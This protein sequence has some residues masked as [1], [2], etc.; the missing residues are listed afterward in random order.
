MQTQ[1][2]NPVGELMQD[3]KLVFYPVGNYRYAYNYDGNKGVSEADPII[4]INDKGKKVIV[5]WDIDFGGTRF[6]FKKKPIKNLITSMPLTNNDIEEWQRLK[7]PVKSDEVYRKIKSG[8][9]V[10]FDFVRERDYDVAA[11]FVLQSWFSDLLE[12]VFYLEI[13][14]RYG[15]GKTVLLEIFEILC[16]NGLLMNEISFAAI[17]RCIENY[18]LTCLI[19]EIDSLQKK[20]RYEIFKILRAGYRK[21]SQYIRLK[22]KTFEVECFKVF[23]AKAFNYRS[24]IPDDL[25]SRSISVN[26][27]K[28]DDKFLP[29]LNFY[30][31]QILRNVFKICWFFYMDSVVWLTKLTNLVGLKVIKKDRIGEEKEPNVP[32]SSEF[33]PVRVKE[34]QELFVNLVNQHGGGILDRAYFTQ[35]LENCHLYE[36]SKKLHEWLTNIS[37]RNIELFFL[38]VQLCE[39]VNLEIADWFIEIFEEKEIT[40]AVDVTEYQEALKEVLVDL[41]PVA[42]DKDGM[43]IIKHRKVAQEFNLKIKETMGKNPTAHE[44]KKQLREIGFIDSVNRKVIKIGGKSHLCLIYDKKI[45]KMLGVEPQPKEEQTEVVKI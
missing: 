7:E 39:F 14:S 12:A 16:K 4:E 30:K 28:S 17:P 6:L 45:Q 40:E 33:F 37:G 43:L 2:L 5:G 11:L 26:L 8:I 19:D 31:K 32:N 3:I 15:S 18:K 27:A 10:C 25:K 23:G 41:F 38:I 42:D 21:G 24:D 44:M 34:L 20:E 36:P 9:K 1:S 22:P 13:K 29:I 35:I